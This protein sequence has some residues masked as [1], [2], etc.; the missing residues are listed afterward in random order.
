M[1][2]FFSSTVSFDLS[3]SQL[4]NKTKVTAGNPGYELLQKTENSYYTAILETDKYSYFA[5]SV[6][7]N[8]QE[9][10]VALRSK[11]RSL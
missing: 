4:E 1:G 3:L 7:F 8:V 5:Y 10:A 11:D 2:F 9:L 6:T